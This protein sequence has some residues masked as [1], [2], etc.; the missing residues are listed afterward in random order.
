MR[1]GWFRID[2]VQDGDR[3]FEQQLEGLRPL[4][5]MVPGKTV[6]DVGCAEG[7]I[8]NALMD[9]GAKSVTG[10]EVVKEHVEAARALYGRRCAFV[11]GDA[12]LYRPPRRYDVVLLL[13]VLHKLKDPVGSCIRFADA[14]LESVVIRLPPMDAP[15]KDITGRGPC[16]IPLISRAMNAAGWRFMDITTGPFNEWTSY[17]RRG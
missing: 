4:F 3:T 5:Q 6:L 14:A 7:L 2:G 17:W 13:A 8:S 11:H 9:A 10:I 1:K 15:P 16:S 12:D